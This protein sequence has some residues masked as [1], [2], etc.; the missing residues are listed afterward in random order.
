MAKNIGINVQVEFK[1]A[2]EGF[3]QLEKSMKKVHRGATEFGRIFGSL[4]EEAGQFGKVFGSLAQALASGSVW[5]LAAAGIMLVVDHFK[6]ANKKI[7]EQKK[8]LK[9]L[10]DEFARY[11]D[12]ARAARLEELGWDAEMLKARSKIIELDNKLAPQ[13]ERKSSLERTLQEFDRNRANIDKLSDVLV[14]GGFA[15]GGA[16]G[17]LQ[18]LMV[19]ESVKEG[20]T[21]YDF[22]TGGRAAIVAQIAEQ[23]RLLQEGEQAREAIMDEMRTRTRIKEKEKE[24]KYANDVREERLKI[25]KESA[26]EYDRVWMEYTER[27]K[28]YPMLEAEAYAA[29]EKRVLQILEDRA[30]KA[31]KIVLDGIQQTTNALV[32]AQQAG[33]EF[34]TPPGADLKKKPGEVIAENTATINKRRLQGIKDQVADLTDLGSRMGSTF[35]S[36]FAEMA[37]SGA[38]FTEK[39]IAIMQLLIQTLAQVILKIVEK[40]AITN[41][42]MTL[43]A[44]AAAIK[45]AKSAAD[46]PGIGWL[47]AIPTAAAVL[48]GLLGLIS[49]R[50]EG[51]PVGART[52]YL[53]G[54]RGPELFVPNTNGGIVPN[55]RLGQM[56]G[57]TVNINASIVD[58]SWWKANRLN[59]IEQINQAARNRQI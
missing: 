14:K 9:E 19:G 6:E 23:N 57:V 56:G 36:A 33:G 45:S 22:Y 18:G 43:D 10:R 30:A 1:D 27:V 51:G 25:E 13:R 28:K 2:R 49:A 8:A 32:A 35:A 54:E 48:S 11:G 16:F 34:E 50:A 5:G 29:A 38:T 21:A 59:I 55:N 17:A 24:K 42:E 15:G 7:E 20:V 26:D 46:I 53:V 47:I 3:E 41:A 39:L 31:E 40:M 52:P 44:E 58:D 4:G 37:V 12:D